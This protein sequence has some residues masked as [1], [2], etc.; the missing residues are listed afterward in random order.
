MTFLIAISCLLVSAYF[1]H[2]SVRLWKKPLY[3]MGIAD[4]SRAALKVEKSYKLAITMT[5]ALIS[6]YFSMDLFI[7]EFLKFSGY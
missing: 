1:F 6:L 3:M 2:A 7:V 5:F 4:Y